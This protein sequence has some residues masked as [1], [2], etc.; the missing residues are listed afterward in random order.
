MLI[1]TMYNYCITEVEPEGS[2]PPEAGPDFWAR[3]KGYVDD[4]ARLRCPVT[5]RP[6][7][8]PKSNANVFSAGAAVG[9]CEHDRKIVWTAKSGEVHTSDR[10]S[11][12]HLKALET[13]SFGYGWR[14]AGTVWTLRAVHEGGVP[15][16]VEIKEV[17]SMGNAPGVIVEISGGLLKDPVRE[18]LYHTDRG[19]LKYGGETAADLDRWLKQVGSDDADERDAA[20]TELA[21][22]YPA[23]RAAVDEALSGTDP[24]MKA[25]LRVIRA[26]SVEFAPVYVAYPL[27]G[28]AA[29]VQVGDRVAR[30]R[31]CRLD[32]AEIVWSDEYDMFISLKRGA[33]EWI[34]ESYS[35]R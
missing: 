5:G 30:G 2:F 32:D 15:M 19:I 8:G 28:D 31:R 17:V 9:L 22:R 25:R 14:G 13:I 26:R 35:P 12:Q 16:R 7:A 3:L 27:K 24:E 21:R 1:K 29:E 18:E 10:D 6:Y 33:K 23:S 4:D 11:K 20:T 34:L